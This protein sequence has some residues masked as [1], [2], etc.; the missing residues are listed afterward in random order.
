[1]NLYLILKAIVTIMYT[2]ELCC[3]VFGKK[4]NK[5]NHGIWAIL[6]LIV[7]FS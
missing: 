6:L 2:Y 1:M 4:E 7:A 3:F 5:T